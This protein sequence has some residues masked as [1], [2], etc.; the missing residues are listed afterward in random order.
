MST[1]PSATPLT[2]SAIPGGTRSLGFKLRF[3]TYATVGFT[4]P[5]IATE[6]SQRKAAGSS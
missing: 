3:W 5:F 6:I 2:P 4:L 1:C